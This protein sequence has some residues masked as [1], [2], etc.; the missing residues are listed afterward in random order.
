[1]LV[2]GAAGF[3]G[4]HLLAALRTA[5][6]QARLVG[7]CHAGASVSGADEAL[8]LDLLDAP[9]IDRLVAVVRPEACIH[10]AAISA[11]QPSFADPDAVWRVNVDGTRSL[12]EALLR[13]VPGCVLLHASSAEVYGLS[14][15][16]GTPLDEQA[17]MQPANPYAAAKAA[18]DICLGEMALRGLRVLR[19]RP[20]NHI[21]PGQSTRFV[22]AAFARQVARIEAGQ[23]PPVI[24]AGA[25]DRRRD[26]LDVRDVCSA[27]VAA[28][29]RADALPPGSALNIASGHLR[30]IGE[31]LDDLLRLAGV[32]AT[33]VATPAALR[34]I[35]LMETACSAAAARRLLDWGPVLPWDRTL[36]DILAHWR[37]AVRQPP[38]AWGTQA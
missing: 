38:A 7:T 30:G 28:L 23:Q 11:V 35:D 4:G 20:L 25:L 5:L 6:P 21:G 12:A 3:V 10:L 16:A 36:Q 18:A 37:D 17:A 2:T 24:E 15:R 26:F 27:Y 13:Q 31:V 14:F 8:A 22:V 32:T 1:V 19:L 9:A 34:P 29:L 33:V